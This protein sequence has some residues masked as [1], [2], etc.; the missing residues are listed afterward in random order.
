V[1][2][3]LEDFAEQANPRT[4]VLAAG[5]TEALMRR[6]I[7]KG[8]FLTSRINWA[9]QSSGVD[10]LHLL[11][12]AMDYL[13]RRFNIDARLMITVHDEIRYLVKEQDKYKAAMALQVS[14]V[15]TRAMFTQQLGINDLP[16]AVAY[17][18]AVDVDFV[19]RKEVDLEC[20]TPSHPKKIGPGESLDIVKLLEKGE[21]AKLDETVIP[22]DPPQLQKYEYT[23]REPVIKS[24]E[25]SD[26]LF[27]LRA[28]IT[29][30]DK[31]LRQIIK[32]KDAIYDKVTQR[33]MRK[34][35]ESS[36]P[37][38]MAK[39]RPHYHPQAPN[40]L[41]VDELWNPNGKSFVKS[42]EGTKKAN[43]WTSF[44]GQRT[45]NR[46]IGRM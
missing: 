28:Q 43:G 18:S 5:I 16:Q 10:Y 38:S 26:D 11:I 40:L 35:L 23:S 8:G 14:N 25:E 42:W 20:V 39:D 30:D 41:P 27:Y 15:W 45:K 22:V 31:E 2:N 19:L 1:F 9:I 6:Y 13:I 33:K 36:V 32:E 4:P 3:R 21:K 46:A 34:A 24:L 12:V 44:V 7:N 29:A 17:F 37:S